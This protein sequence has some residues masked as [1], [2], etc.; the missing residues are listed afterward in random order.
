MGRI[1]YKHVKDKFSCQ[2]CCRYG[3]ISL[4]FPLLFK[5]NFLYIPFN[6]SLQLFLTMNTGICQYGGM[7]CFV[8]VKVGQSKEMCFVTSSDVVAYLKG[9]KKPTE[10][11][12]FSKKKTEGCHLVVKSSVN[13]FGPFSFLSMNP[14]SSPELEIKRERTCLD[15]QVPKQNLESEFEAYTFVGSE[16]L[17]L[18]FAYQR[19]TG[20]YSLSTKRK[21]RLELP[22]VLGAPIIIENKDVTCKRL[23]RRWPVVGVIGLNEEWE[24]CPYF[25]TADIFGEFC[26][27]LYNPV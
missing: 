14:Q 19:G 18:K 2:Q 8:M 16:T 6:F 27:Y 5:H 13:K 7:A 17:K 26:W 1:S 12:P 24:L 23:S 10:M 22:F 4:H 3:C 21:D 9:D 11:H 20:K 25:V 15:F